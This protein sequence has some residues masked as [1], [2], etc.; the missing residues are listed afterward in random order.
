MKVY[1]IY[2]YGR[3]VREINGT[4]ADLLKWIQENVPAQ[5]KA[6]YRTGDPTF[7]KPLLYEDARAA[8]ITINSKK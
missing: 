3:L 6:S 2:R 8:G 1:R 5:N 7:N 4:E